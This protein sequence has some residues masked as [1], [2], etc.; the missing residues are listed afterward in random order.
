MRKGRSNEARER[1]PVVLRCPTGP[2]LA[3]KDPWCLLGKRARIARILRFTI[4]KLQNPKGALQPYV[5]LAQ[6]AKTQTQR[7][8]ASRFLVL[9]PADLRAGAKAA[10]REQPGLCRARAHGPEPGR[11]PYARVDGPRQGAGQERERYRAPVER[12]PPPAG[13]PSR[14]PR[15]RPEHRLPAAPLDLR[16]EGRAARRPALPRKSL[17]QPRQDSAAELA[18]HAVR[19]Q[20][21]R[22]EGSGRVRERRRFRFLRLYARPRGNH[23]VR[24][25]LENLHR[26]LPRGLSCDP[27][28]SGTGELRHLRRSQVGHRRSLFGTGG[29]REGWVRETRDADLRQVA[30]G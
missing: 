10:L 6:F 1:T 25:E 27:L 28:P 5:R 23:G 12:L 16:H 8:A 11:L 20:T 7:I 2:G 14:R 19:G 15:Q 13:D 9:R 30:R 26:G 21:R 4:Y 29:G 22:G 18:R 3:R 24:A 17:P